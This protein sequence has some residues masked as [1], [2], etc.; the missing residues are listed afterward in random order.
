M[1]VVVAVKQIRLNGSF[2]AILDGMLPRGWE[3]EVPV[4]F[5][6]N[7]DDVVFL[8]HGV[9]LLAALD[10][11]CAASWVVA[12]TVRIVSIC[13]LPTRR[14]ETY[15]TVYIKCGRFPLE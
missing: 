13:Y 11:C 8:A 2:S 7:N 9:D 4:R 15:V 5:I 10:G 1:R 3:L 14:I 12:E 6:L